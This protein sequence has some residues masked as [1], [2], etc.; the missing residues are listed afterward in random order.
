MKL[1][2]MYDLASL[3][4]VVVTTTLV[5]KLVE[6]DFASPLDLDAPVERYLPEWANGPQPE[7]RHRVTV[8][9]LMTHTS[10]LPPFK[11]YWRTSTGK[12]DT[13]NQYFC[14]TVGV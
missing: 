2:T 5:E 10:G 14:G 11:E 12:Q 8:C 6:G 13:L 9:H 7:W 3:T 1:D 4:K